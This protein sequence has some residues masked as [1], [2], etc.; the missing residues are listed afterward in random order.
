MFSLRA[1]IENISVMNPWSVLADQGQTIG[2]SADRYQ[3]RDAMAQLK[4]TH[5]DLI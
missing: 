3:Y 1:E 4:Q 5:L 2:L